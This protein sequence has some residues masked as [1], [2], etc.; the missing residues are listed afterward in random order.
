MA[1]NP[2][3][4]AFC[5]GP[6]GEFVLFLSAKYQGIYGV[7][8]LTYYTPLLSFFKTLN[9]FAGVESSYKKNTRIDN[10]SDFP[11]LGPNQNALPTCSWPFPPN[12]IKLW[13]PGKVQ[14]PC[15]LNQPSRA[16]SQTPLVI[17]ATCSNRDLSKHFFIYNGAVMLPRGHTQ[18]QTLKFRALPVIILRQWAGTKTS[19]VTTGVGKQNQPLAPAWRMV[20]FHKGSL[21]NKKNIWPKR[22]PDGGFLINFKNY[23]PAEAFRNTESVYLTPPTLPALPNYPLVGAWPI[24]YAQDS[25]K[26]QPGLTNQLIGPSANDHL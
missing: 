24:L 25:W 6:F 23:I 7:P 26:A 3:K 20:A 22:F 17:I 9:L 16:P 14:V 13:P 11:W 10:V 15:S 5:G 1:Q 12:T 21:N 19:Q 2:G 4:C 8:T 18:K